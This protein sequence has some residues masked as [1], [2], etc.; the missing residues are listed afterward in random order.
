MSNCD[1]VDSE[2]LTERG[3]ELFLLWCLLTMIVITT[4]VTSA[5]GQDASDVPMGKSQPAVASPDGSSSSDFAPSPFGLKPVWA[6]QVD[7]R[8]RPGQNVGIEDDG[9]TAEFVEFSAD[10]KR[11]VSFCCGKP[12]FARG[13]RGRSE[14]F[15][16]KRSFVAL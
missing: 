13:G 1:E 16:A 10:G 14:R 3:R 4:A 6:K 9:I 11:L 7:S 5:P 15:A 2:D 8:W 12:V